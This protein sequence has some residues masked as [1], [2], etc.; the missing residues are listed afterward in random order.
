MR[1]ILFRGKREDN[2]QW[3]HGDLCTQDSEHCAMIGVWQKVS[4]PFVEWIPVLDYTVGQFTG[5]VDENGYKIFEGDIDN[6]DSDATGFVVYHYDGYGIK[7]SQEQ[8]YVET[9]IQW[10]KTTIC[11]NIHDNPELVQTQKYS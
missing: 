6:S 5:N 7:F 11:G 3:V 1:E 10:D 9:C 4:N 2:G 8:D